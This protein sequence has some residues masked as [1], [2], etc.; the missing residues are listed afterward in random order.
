MDPTTWPWNLP[1]SVPLSLR[2]LIGRPVRTVRPGD[3]ITLEY[4]AGRVTFFLDDAG[5]VADIGFEPE[6]PATRSA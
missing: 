4:I 6:E 3:V 2:D 1:Q 5:L